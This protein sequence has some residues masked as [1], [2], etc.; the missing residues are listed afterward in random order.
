M[1]SVIAPGDAP[2]AP[3][4]PP[5]GR[6]PWHPETLAWWAGLW[7]SPMAPEFDQA[8]DLPE[9]LRLARL[10]DAYNY[11][12]EPK[13]MIQLMAE[14]RLQ[15]QCFGL[16]PLDRRRLQWEIAKGD[17]AESRT[18]AR[19]APRAASPKADPRAK[20]SGG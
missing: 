19:R 6:I 4:L 10:V 17:E 3:G 8:T 16:T 12:D 11:T 14:I 1:L 2:D 13:L 5:P 15:R 20:A 18:K 7:R 9:L